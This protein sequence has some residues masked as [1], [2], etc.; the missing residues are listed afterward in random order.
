[1]NASEEDANGTNEPGEGDDDAGVVRDC[2]ALVTFKISV[3]IM[4]QLGQPGGPELSDE[5]KEGAGKWVFSALLRSMLHQ[6][7]A[8]SDEK[9][10]PIM[11]LCKVKPFETSEDGQRSPLEQTVI[12]VDFPETDVCSAMGF[13]KYVCGDYDSGEEEL[14]IVRVASMNRDTIMNSCN[15]GAR[16]TT[17]AIQGLWTQISTVHAVA[18]YQALLLPDCPANSVRCEARAHLC[19][20]SEPSWKCKCTLGYDGE[21]TIPNLDDIQ[22]T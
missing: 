9:D 5:E 8:E 4:G 21:I 17:G 18:L 15:W 1:M 14:I 12:S 6:R 19:E 22:G 3:T 7:S 20:E 13:G 16:I 11:G 2:D 10:L